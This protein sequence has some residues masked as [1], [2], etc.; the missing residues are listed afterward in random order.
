MRISQ[1]GKL[2]AGIEIPAEFADRVGPEPPTR[3]DYPGMGK[4]GRLQTQITHTKIVEI[5][6]QI[7]ILHSSGLTFCYEI[8][9]RAAERTPEKA[10]NQTTIQNTGMAVT[11]LITT[12][13]LVASVSTPAY[14][15]LFTGSEQRRHVTETEWLRNKASNCKHDAATVE[16][17]LGRRDS[18][19]SVVEVLLAS[20]EDRYYVNIAANHWDDK[21][22]ARDTA[23]TLYR[24]CLEKGTYWS[25]LT[26]LEAV[27]GE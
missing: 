26:P 10:M 5:F 22:S 9:Y 18:G 14:S 16:R 24:Y 3:T 4:Q 7:G 8:L 6:R 2:T 15:Q 19:G 12:V 11:K 1:L 23:R 21:G 13:I 27:E 17:L 20:T 25:P